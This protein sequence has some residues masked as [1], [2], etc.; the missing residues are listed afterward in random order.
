M[1]VKNMEPKKNW[2]LNKSGQ[3]VTE[4]VLIV[5]LVGIV[6]ISSLSMVGGS[7]SNVFTKS[8]IEFVV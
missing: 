7:V 5:A 2:H 6:A 8:R 1:K 3:A 4:Y